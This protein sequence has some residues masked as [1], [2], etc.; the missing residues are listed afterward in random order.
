MTGLGL[1]LDDNSRIDAGRLPIAHLANLE[2]LRANPRS[3]LIKTFTHDIRHHKGFFDPSRRHQD[4][5]R[6]IRAF[7]RTRL[8]V[9]LLYRQRL[10]GCVFA[11][12]KYCPSVKFRC[13]R[14][15]F[16]ARKLDPTRF[17]TA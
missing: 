7:L 5:Y 4:I 2:S 15:S 16:A 8:R 12:S 3:N 1:L 9:L 6:R 17:G 13:S 11:S 10:A 14:V